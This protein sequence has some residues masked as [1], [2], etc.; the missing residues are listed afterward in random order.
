MEVMSSQDTGNTKNSQYT[1]RQWDR[2]VG[3]EQVPDEYN[4]ALHDKCGTSDC[5][6]QCSTAVKDIVK[7]T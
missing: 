3:Y 5:C 4:I 7:K 6:G 1:Q 2:T